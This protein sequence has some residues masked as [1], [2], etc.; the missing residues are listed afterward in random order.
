MRPVNHKAQVVM[1]AP[2]ACAQTNAAQADGLTEG[3]QSFQVVVTD[4]AGNKATAN[5]AWTVDLTPPEVRI[6]SGPDAVT[7]QSTA[8]FTFTGSDTHG[9]DSAGYRCRINQLPE[10]PCTSPVEYSSLAEGVHL[11]HHV[12][13]YGWTPE[14]IQKHQLSSQG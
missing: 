7:N 10:A 8:R 9:M 6:T 1:G 12:K 13:I 5:A 4:R 14:W 2:R 3:A 11:I